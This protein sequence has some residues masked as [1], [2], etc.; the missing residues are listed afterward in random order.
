MLQIVTH[1]GLNFKRKDPKLTNT[2]IYQTSTSELFG[3]IQE[4]P[5]KETTPYP[6]SPYAAAKLYA[7]WI[8]LIS[9]SMAC[10]HAMEFFLIMR[11][12][13]EER[14]SYKKNYEFSKN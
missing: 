2:R 7:Y 6:R 5:Q 1:L 14:L 8:K 13:E 9:R 11:A 12:L 3:K 10:L 4:T